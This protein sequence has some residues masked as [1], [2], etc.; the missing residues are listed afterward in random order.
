MRHSEGTPLARRMGLVVIAAVMLAAVALPAVALA[1]TPHS[2][3]ATTYMYMSTAKTFTISG[4]IA[5]STHGKKMTIEIRKPG[6]SFWTT[7]STPVISS[8]G[9]WSTKYFPKLGGKFYIRA[10]Y[11]TSTAGLSRTAYVIV[12]RGPGVRYVLRLASTTSTRDSGLFEALRPIFQSQMPEYDLQAVFVGSGASIL[13]GATGDADVLLTHSPQAEI[14]FMR[15]L[16]GSP[17]A[18]SAYKGL[19]RFKVMYN[20]FVLV[21]PT[22]NPAGILDGDTPAV[23]FGKI[24]STGSKFWSRN[25]TSGTAVKEKSI[26]ASISNPQIGQSW[27]YASGVMGMAQALSA[28]NNGGGYTLSDRSTWMNAVA[29]S[30]VSGLKIV[31]EGSSI[32]FNQYSVIEVARARNAEGAQDFRRWIMSPSVQTVIRNY[33]LDT[34]GK[35]VFKPNAGSY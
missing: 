10:R 21:G 34:F 8:T 23:A 9:R 13:K 29:M 12:R 27:Y 16:V 28:A 22:A 25:D 1:T 5:A 7:V 15:G 17:L 11:G 33:G 20:D 19:T 6:R 35:S 14:D 3:I 26:W 18:P 24:A 30:T 32:Y 31:N 4:H 2:T